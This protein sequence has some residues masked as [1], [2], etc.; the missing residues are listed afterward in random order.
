MYMT[1]N[2]LL[3]AFVLLLAG[4]GYWLA[5]KERQT[6]G[7]TIDTELLGGDETDPQVVIEHNDVIRVFAPQENAVVG[8]PL[9]IQG[10][11]RGPWYFEATFSVRLIDANGINVPL[12]PGYIMTD[13]VWMTTE[14]VPFEASLDFSVPVTETGTLI[15]EKA[16]PSGLPIHADELH[17]PV[18]F[19]D[20]GATAPDLQ[21]VTLYY[22]DPTLDEDETGNIMCTSAGLVP[23]ER[24]IPRTLS[25]ARDTIELLLAGDLTPAE[26]AAGVTTEFPLPGFSLTDIRLAEGVLTL[27]FADPEQASGGGSCRVGILWNQIRH[28]AE[29]FETVDEVRFLPETLFQP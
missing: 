17:I 12:T 29:Q 23:V 27:E 7:S 9:V 2:V 1:R 20:N 26:R 11:A 10:E 4:G 14:Y 13:E 19:S 28:T 5:T 24:E 18:R 15:L 22:Y 6:A 3:I 21:T 8:S 16:N 25:P